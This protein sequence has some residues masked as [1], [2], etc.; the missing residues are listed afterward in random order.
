MLTSIQICRIYTQTFSSSIDPVNTHTGDG[1]RC[2]YSSFPLA[3][4]FVPA[5]AE[6]RLFINTYRQFVWTNWIK[7]WVVAGN[8]CLGCFPFGS[9]W[10]NIPS[11]LRLEVRCGFGVTARDQQ[12][13]GRKQ[14]VVHSKLSWAWR[15]GQEKERWV[16]SLLRI[17]ADGRRRRR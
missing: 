14:K 9:S 17:R 7:G 16:E 1:H 6:S 10:S 3:H 12:S 4:S 15:Q 5:V 13:E 8:Y 2:V 11:W